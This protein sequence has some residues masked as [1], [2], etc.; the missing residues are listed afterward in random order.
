MLQGCCGPWLIPQGCCGPFPTSLCLQKSLGLPRAIPST[1]SR[2]KQPRCKT[3]EVSGTHAPAGSCILHL[4][5]CPGATN[6]TRHPEPIPDAAA[7]A[8]SAGVSPASFQRG[9]LKRLLLVRRHRRQETLPLSCTGSP[10]IQLTAQIWCEEICWQ[11]TRG[12]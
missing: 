11:A 4:C 9:I 2:K 12:Q 1:S 5:G 10:Y 6:P 3:R 8:T 7:I